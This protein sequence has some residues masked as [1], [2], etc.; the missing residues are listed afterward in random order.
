MH[1]SLFH[2]GAPTIRNSGMAGTYTREGGFLSYYEV[3]QKLKEGKLTEQNAFGTSALPLFLA[4]WKREWSSQQ[5]VPY[6]YQG[7]DWVGYDDRESIRLKVNDRRS[8]P[9]VT[10]MKHRRRRTSKT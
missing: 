3:C 10:R 9:T 8:P 5:E 6:A 4:G 1:P 7:S 2:L